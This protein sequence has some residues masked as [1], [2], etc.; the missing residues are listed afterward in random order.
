MVTGDHSSWLSLIF[1]PALSPPM[2]PGS[3]PLL[4]PSWVPFSGCSLKSLNPQLPAP[5]WASAA[6]QRANDTPAQ[7]LATSEA[8][9]SQC[10]PTCSCVA[11]NICV[12]AFHIYILHV[13]PSQTC[14]LAALAS[15][16][17]I[18]VHPMPLDGA[19]KHMWSQTSAHTAKP[20]WPSL[21]LLSYSPS[22]SI[23][24][25]EGCSP[26]KIVQAS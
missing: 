3:W 11:Q 22:S 15:L 10:H 1:A 23:S 26:T 19:A 6:Q 24:S 12:Y 14:A 17:E 2:Q 13:C 7:G 16:S 5:G 8:P 9:P 25:L 20:A 4:P 18:W 21:A